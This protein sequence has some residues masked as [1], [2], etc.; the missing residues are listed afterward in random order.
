MGHCPHIRKS[1]PLQWNITSTAIASPKFIQIPGRQRNKGIEEQ[2]SGN[3]V[4]SRQGRGPQM[5]RWTQHELDEIHHQSNGRCRNCG[6]YHRREKHGST[7]NVDH[8]IPR[9]RGGRDHISNLRLNCIRCN[10]DKSDKVN[11]HDVAEVA[12]NMVSNR[13]R[14]RT[15]NSKGP[16]QRG[17]MPRRNR[18][19]IC[20]RSKPVSQAYCT[21]CTKKSQG[22]PVKK[23]TGECKFGRCHEPVHS[24]FFGLLNDPYCPRH[25][26]QYR[27]GLIGEPRE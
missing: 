10:S 25:M 6:K 27:R 18:C 24:N 20:K 3:Q 15:D 7:W 11:L 23:F 19:P 5:P 4:Q 12:A 8:V 14:G 22:M 2:G 26:E 21:S 17:N 13:N 1:M 9:A 16:K